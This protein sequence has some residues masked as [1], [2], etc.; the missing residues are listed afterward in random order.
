M[1]IQAATIPKELRDL[2]SVSWDN[3]SLLKN[4]VIS[5]VNYHGC[6]GKR[7]ETGLNNAVLIN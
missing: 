6:G 4:M 2:L 3:N 5:E 1:I 7:P